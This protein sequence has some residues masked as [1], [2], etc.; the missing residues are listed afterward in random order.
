[1]IIDPE[2][3]KGA[4]V[5]ARLRDE[6]VAWLVTVSPDGT[7]VPT[8]VWYWWDGSTILVYSQ[9]GTPKLRHIAANPRVALA[10][11]TDEH[12]DALVVITGRAA[13]DEAAPRADELEGYLAKYDASIERLG[14][15]PA[16]FG[17]EYS[18][19]IRIAPTRLRAW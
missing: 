4:R 1:V 14:S 6:L 19:P 5:D 8:P 13:V 9:P 7:P 12:G 3:E 11:R 2:T 15:T 16:E 17:A 10:M 18:V